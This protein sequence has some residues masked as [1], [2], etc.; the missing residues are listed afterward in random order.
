MANRSDVQLMLVIHVVQ[1]RHA[2]EQEMYWNKTNKG[3]YRFRACLH[4]S[5]GPQVGEVTC[6]GVHRI[7]QFN[8]ITFT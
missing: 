3:N 6:S 1:N 5:E 4:G 2:G 7:S 8:L